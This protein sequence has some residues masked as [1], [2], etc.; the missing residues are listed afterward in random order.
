MH[1]SQK[2]SIA[3]H[4]LIFINEYGAGNRVTSQLLGLSTGCNPVTVR[5]ILSALKKAGIIA[6][7][8]GAGGATLARPLGEITL[9]GVCQAVEPDCLEKLVGVHGS[10]SPLCPVGRNIG[11]VLDT[12]YGRLREDVADSLRRVTM[13]QIVDEYHAALARGEEAPASP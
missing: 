12:T 8:G 10:P 5:G 7:R 6:V 9:Y 1:I 4:C 2:C 13:A 3:V 11:Q